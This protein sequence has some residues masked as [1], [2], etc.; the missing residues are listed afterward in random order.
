MTQP[1]GAPID[2][3]VVSFGRYAGKTYLQI[4]QEHRDY[5]EWVLRTVESGDSPSPALRRLA[6]YLVTKEARETNAPQPEDE[7]MP[8]RR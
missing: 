4:Y 5:T 1:T 7:Q 3:E 2:S 8:D 6:N